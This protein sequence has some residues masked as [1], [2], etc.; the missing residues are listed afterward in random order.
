MARSATE[1]T[2]NAPRDLLGRQVL[3]TKHITEEGPRRMDAA[4][5][6]T[7]TRE[8]LG[9]SLV[10]FPNVWVREL[11]LPRHRPCRRT[12]RAGPRASSRTC[13]VL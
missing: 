6:G 8:R 10:N 1:P 11:S 4:I 12:K 3:H 2:T 9:S 7:R 5:A 13:L